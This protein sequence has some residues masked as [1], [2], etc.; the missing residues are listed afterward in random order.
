M[1][2]PPCNNKQDL[3]CIKCKVRGGSAMITVGKY[4]IPFHASCFKCAECQKQLEANADFVC[5]KNDIFMPECLKKR[6][7][8]A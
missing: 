6:Q 1:I 4:K 8:A 3:V 5:K 7:A 2:C